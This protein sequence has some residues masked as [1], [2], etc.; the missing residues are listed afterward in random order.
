MPHPFPSHFGSGYLYSALIAD[1]PLIANLFV[2]TAGT[3]KVFSRAKDSLA[4]KP[5]SFRLQ[6]TVIDGLWLSYL[7]I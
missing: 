7:T 2:F 4:E 6:S 3:L 1:N 5:V